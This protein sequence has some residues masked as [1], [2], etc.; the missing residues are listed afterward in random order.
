MGRVREEKRREEKR[1]GEE[2]REEKRQSQKK[3]DVGARKNRKVAKHCVFQWSVAPGGSKSRLTKAAGEEPSGQMRDE[4]LHAVVAKHTSKSKCEKHTRFGALLEVEMMKKCTPLWREAHLEVKI[5]KST[6]C[7]DHFWT[8]NCTTLHHNKTLQL[9][10][11][12]LLQLQLQ[13]Q[14]R[15]HYNYN[16]HYHYTATTTTTTATTT[17]HHTKPHHTTV[18][19]CGWVDHCNHSKKHNSNHLSVHQCIR[20]AIHASQQLTSPIVVYLLKLL[21]P[22]CAVLP[23]VI[24]INNQ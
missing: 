22:P 9:Q 20:S 17:L 12:L 14:L 4:K 1:R 8:F 5:A 21:P 6:T 16:Y 23:V 7:S 24:T 3:E 19:N 10:L 18:S 2:R 15:I 13:L 11:Q